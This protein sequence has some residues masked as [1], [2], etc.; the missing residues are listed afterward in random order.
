MEETGTSA[1]L[2]VLRSITDELPRHEQ[3]LNQL[4]AALGDGDHGFT[5]TRCCRAIRRRLDPL[6][7]ATISDALAVVGMA[8]VTDAGGASGALF[9]SAFMAAA[10]AVGDDL[11]VDTARVADI[12]DAARQAIAARGRVSPGDK[13]MLDALAPAASAARRAASS[14]GSVEDAVDA[15]AAAAEK[16]A[17]ATRDMVGRSGRA[18]RLGDRSL[19][20]PDPGAVSVALMLRVAADQLRARGTR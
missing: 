13:T 12:L 10:Q 3:R 8:V 9:G 19:G 7:D 17:A 4:D 6:A 2:D 1:L 5:V 15:A 16:G 18:S 14:G 11:G 20:H